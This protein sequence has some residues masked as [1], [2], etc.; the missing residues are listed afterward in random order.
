MSRI[1]KTRLTNSRLASNQ[2]DT[3]TCSRYLTYG[4]VGEFILVAK[5]EDFR[6]TRVELGEVE[7]CEVDSS[8]AVSSCADD[9]EPVAAP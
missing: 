9:I 7:L 1:V 5:E 4:V 3:S 8:A 6:R 2:K